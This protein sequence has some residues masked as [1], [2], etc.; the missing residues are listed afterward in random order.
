MSAVRSI[1]AIGTLDRLGDLVRRAA[2]PVV[3]FLETGSP[4]AVGLSAAMAFLPWILVVGI[5]SRLGA[6]TRA[7]STLILVNLAR[8]GT[9]VVMAILAAQAN[10]GIAFYLAISVLAALTAIVDTAFGSVIR[11]AG[12]L[13]DLKRLNAR[14]GTWQNGAAAVIGL[15]LGGWL[16][17]VSPGAAFLFDAGTYLVAS[18][19]VVMSAVGLVDVDDG[20]SD[21]H[22]ISAVSALRW[23]VS[24][25]HHAGIVAGVAGLN[26]G[27]GLVFGNLVVV[28]VEQYSVRS[29]LYGTIPLVWSLSVTAG[30]AVIAR[31]EFRNR[32]LLLFAPAA[33]V[34]G[35]SLIAATSLRALL[36]VGLVILG[37]A[38]SGW[39]TASS[40]RMQS[41]PPDHVVAGVLASWKSIAVAAAFFGAGLGGLLLESV[42]TQWV[43][44][45]A[46]AVCGGAGGLVYLTNSR[47]ETTDAV[48][49]SVL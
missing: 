34:V 27:S 42:S 33:Q 44:L 37:L 8:S 40:V 21:T 6:P 24:S 15:P 4:L 48:A 3:I 23:L 46:A 49:G 22:R 20:L 5:S 18:A 45:L 26:I 41:D 31:T 28:A 16:G 29:S 36:V 32:H 13:T 30:S 11:I 17:A 7:R 14:L 47:Q 2:I 39:N 38:A 1:I 35:Y 12:G 9:A 43:L 10:F 19:L 25:R